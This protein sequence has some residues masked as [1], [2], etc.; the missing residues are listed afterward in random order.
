MPWVLDWFTTV[1][2]KE[3]NYELIWSHNGTMRSSITLRSQ[4]ITLSYKG[5][6]YF[7]PKE[8]TLEC[9]LYRVINSYPGMPYYMEDIFVLT[10]EG[11]SMSFKPY[12]QA[13]ICYS[14]FCDK[15]MARFENIPDYFALWNSYGGV[16]RGRYP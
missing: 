14:N 13:E 10:K 6:P 11:F 4:P 1:S 2:L 3:E 9:Y 7:E 5:N 16:S 8:V 12:F 15:K